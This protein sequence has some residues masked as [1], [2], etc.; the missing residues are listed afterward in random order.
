MW[1]ESSDLTRKLVVFVPSDANALRQTCRSYLEAFSTEAVWRDV[2]CCLYWKNGD[3][4]SAPVAPVVGTSAVESVASWRQAADRWR[5]L[6]THMEDEID[7]STWCRVAAAWRVIEKDFGGWLRPGAV[8]ADAPKALKYAYAIHDGQ[9]DSVSAGLFGGYTVYEVLVNTRFLPWAQV[10]IDDMFTFAASD[11]DG[12]TRCFK[13]DADDNV[14]LEDRLASNTAG[15]VGWFETYA[16]YLRDGVFRSSTHGISVFPQAGPYCYV[17]VSHGVKVTASM[18]YNAPEYGGLVYSIRLD[19]EEGAEPCQLKTRRWRITNNAYDPPKVHSV[20][21]AGV[22]GCFP[23][24]EP[25]GYRDDRQA[26]NRP[27]LVLGAAHRGQFAYQSLLGPQFDG[28]EGGTFGGTIDFVPG[29]IRDPTG[30]SFHVD[31]PDIDLKFP[32]FLY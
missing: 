32:D 4:P 15:F 7:A 23:R 9:S 26:H 29:E 25:G 17:S 5:D 27:L 22:V 14:W 10:V 19:L 16:A 31:I 3:C 28:N 20:V 6:A 24:L 11:C 21:G 30:P 18:A 13:A 1:W 2:A 8:I 12:F